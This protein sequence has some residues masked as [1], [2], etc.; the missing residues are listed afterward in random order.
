[1]VTKEYTWHNRYDSLQDV[2][3]ISEGSSYYYVVFRVVEI[4]VDTMML[5]DGKSDGYVK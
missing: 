5:L 3:H 4:F 2:E 1:M